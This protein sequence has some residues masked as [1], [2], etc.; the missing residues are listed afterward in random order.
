MKPGGITRSS[1]DSSA[2]D[3]WPEPEQA[4]VDARAQQVEHVLHARLPVGPEAP[5]VRPADHHG[6]R[7]EGERLHDVAAAPHAAV[8]QHLDLVADRLGDVGQQPDRGRGAVQVVPAVVG[9]RDRGDARVD[10]PLGVVDPGDA[11]EHERARPTATAARRR[12]PRTAGPSASTARRRRRTSAR[13]RRRPAG[14]A[15][16]G[17]GSRR[18]RSHCVQPRGPGQRRGRL[19]EHLLRSVIFSGIR[20]EPQS[21]PKEN[22]QSSVTMTP[23]AP[24]PSRPLHPGRHVVAACRPSTS[25]RTSSGWPR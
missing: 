10:G 24:A 11:L 8:E 18:T 21:R 5:Q 25:G 6:P 17:R 3:E 4:G 16:S 9:H 1:G 20:G 13:A 15:R 23:T 22:D 14:S 19:P 7:A 2:I 12:P